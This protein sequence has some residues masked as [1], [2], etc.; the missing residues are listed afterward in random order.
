MDHIWSKRAK[1]GQKSAKTLFLDKSTHME[2]KGFVPFRVSTALRRW[3]ADGT[4]SWPGQKER[5]RTPTQY[6]TG[7][8]RKQIKE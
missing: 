6:Q 1:N 7:F 5:S 2:R 3:L 8:D 4:C